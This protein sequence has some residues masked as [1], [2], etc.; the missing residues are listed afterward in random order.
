MYRRCFNSTMLPESCRQR[1]ERHR[2]SGSH[3]PATRPT[4]LAGPFPPLLSRSCSRCCERRHYH[5][6]DLDDGRRH[7]G[8]IE[9]QDHFLL[10]GGA[11]VECIVTVA[12]DVVVGVDDLGEIAGLIVEGGGDAPLGVERLDSVVAGVVPASRSARASMPKPHPARD[13][14]SRRVGWGAIHMM[15]SSTAAR[16]VHINPGK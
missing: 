2:H 14:H 1:P 5:L 8:N 10:D 13:S 16:C 6:P 7:C 3:I 9:L 12:G 4:Y 11:Q 15:I